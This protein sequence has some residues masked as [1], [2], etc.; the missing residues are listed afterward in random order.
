MAFTT[1]F[2]EITKTFFRSIRPLHYSKQKMLRILGITHTAESVLQGFS[3]TELA[4]RERAAELAQL[5]LGMP[6]VQQAAD[7]AGLARLR[8]RD[9]RRRLLSQA[10]SRVY[11]A[12]S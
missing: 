1:N 5:G 10:N 11:V 9:L 12:L 2:L 6:Q 7:V 3:P 4:G 8:S